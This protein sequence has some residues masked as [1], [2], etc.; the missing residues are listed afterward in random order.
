MV[1]AGMA[2]AVVLTTTVALAQAPEWWTNRHVL[3]IGATPNDYA[4]VNQGQVKWA[5]TQAAAELAANG[6]TSS[7]ITALL[8]SFSPTNNYLPVN[9]GQLKYVAAPF[10]DL[11]TANGLTNGYLNCYPPAASQLIN[12]R[13]IRFGWGDSCTVAPTGLAVQLP[14]QHQRRH[15]SHRTTGGTIN[16]PCSR[17][18]IVAPNT[19]PA[20][21][22]CQIR[23]LRAAS[24][25]AS[26]AATK[27]TVVSMSSAA[28][29]A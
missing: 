3:V 17:T 10:Y 26:T 8:A 9:L 15:A 29:C 19:T 28:R 24:V 20:S 22:K 21:A 14:L 5:V 16:N 11:L 27:N 6:L 12:G 7:N 2:L 13:T 1:V 25:T 4:A 23:P 18:S